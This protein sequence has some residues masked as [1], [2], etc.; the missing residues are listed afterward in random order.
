MIK[1]FSAKNDVINPVLVPNLIPSPVSRSSPPSPLDNRWWRWGGDRW[2]GE[3]GDSLSDVAPEWLL[4]STLGCFLEAEAS[5]CCVINKGLTIPNKARTPPPKKLGE[6]RQNLMSFDYSTTLPL[7][8]AGNRVSA[9]PDAQ[10]QIP[11]GSKTSDFSLWKE[12]NRLRRQWSQLQGW[13]IK[14]KNV[15]MKVLANYNDSLIILISLKENPFLRFWWT[16]L[17]SK[18]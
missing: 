17:L 9:R 15:Y 3:K 18:P 4:G 14:Y 12:I 1:W 7:D 11:L 6:G 5:V 13:K 10:S 2:E 16:V 8:P